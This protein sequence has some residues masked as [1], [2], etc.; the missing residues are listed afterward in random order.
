MVLPV[1]DVGQLSSDPR[2]TT[3]LR[4][5]RLLGQPTRAHTRCPVLP[6]AMS[7]TDAAYGASAARARCR[8][9]SSSSGACSANS[10]TRNSGTS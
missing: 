4:D 3:A 7:G 8:R 10:N 2:S 5:V 1:E 9:R 6:Y